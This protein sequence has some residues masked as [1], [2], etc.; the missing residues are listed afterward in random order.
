V[1]DSIWSYATPPLTLPRPAFELW[2]PL[3][4][5]VFATPMA[6]LGETF[7]AAQL[8][9]ALVGGLLAPLAWLVARDTA[10]RLGLP[11]RRAWFV[12]VGAGALAAVAGPLALSAAVPDSYVVFTVAAVAA[13]V[14]MP[15]A[16]AGSRFALVGLGVL[17]GVAYL[18]RM[19]AI[20]LGAAF[21][22][23]LAVARAGWRTIL[24]RAAAVA[25]VGALVAT[26]WWLRNMS[27]FGSALPGQVADNVFLTYNEQIFSFADQPTFYG[28]AAQGPLTMATNIGFAFWH[29]L[30]NVLLVPVTAVVVVGLL[31]LAVG[32]ARRRSL[33][34]A[35]R[36]GSLTALLT[37]GALTFITT[38]ILFPVATLW[39]TFEHS[40]GPLLVGLVVAAA[41]GADAFV[42]WLVRRRAW[43]RQNAWLAPAALLALT[44]PI[45]AFQIAVAS[46]QAATDQG[47]IAA[48]ATAVPG[49][50]TSAGVSSDA[51]V[52][53]DRPV[54]LA[55]ALTR[56]TL[57]LPAEPVSTVIALAQ[58]FGAQSVV[59][60]EGRGNYPLALRAQ[61]DCF[62]ELD[63]ASTGG[64]SVFVIARECLR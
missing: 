37:A 48:V 33:P 4:S 59:V 10:T 1:I 6:L 60:V 8:A 61:P 53:T 24:S 20:W 45:A 43:E 58:R 52:I 29:N 18:T 62:T 12:A 11:E 38:S 36:R 9:S 13:C 55:D 27:V 47:T 17:L 31:T 25:V 51:P 54:W 26:P 44:V 63:P 42:A 28:Y 46:R 34:G 23:L 56:E 35:I 3:A 15:R 5:F 30:V 19:E 21:V 7:A 50:L 16:V 14:A 22:V 57:A 2:Q 32:I 49:A 64:S 41:V 40:S 39:G